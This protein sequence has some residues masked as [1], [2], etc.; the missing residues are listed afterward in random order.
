[1]KTFDV[2]EQCHPSQGPGGSEQHGRPRCG[3]EGPIV[4]AHLVKHEGEA[5]GSSEE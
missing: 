3:E 1:M 4:D 5:Q 2:D